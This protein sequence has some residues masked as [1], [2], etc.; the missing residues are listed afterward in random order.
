MAS[1]INAIE[2][3]GARE[4]LKAKQKALKSSWKG[5][6]PNASRSLADS[7][8]DELHR[9]GQIGKWNARS[10]AQ[11]IVA[12]QYYSLWHEVKNTGTFAGEKFNKKKI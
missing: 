11:H 8:V 6:K 1:V 9:K 10:N 7:E 2:F 3:A 4:V 5:N 12:Q